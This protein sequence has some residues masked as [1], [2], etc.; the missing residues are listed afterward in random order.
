[1][2]PARKDRL[3]HGLDDIALTIGH[4]DKIKAYEAWRRKE[5]DWVF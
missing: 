4:A 5:E 1:V 3:L 2:D